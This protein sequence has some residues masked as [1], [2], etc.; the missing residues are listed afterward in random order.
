[1]QSNRGAILRG[2]VIAGGI[3]LFSVLFFSDKTHLTGKN[4]TLESEQSQKGNVSL[5]ALAPDEKTD[6]WIKIVEE[7]K[8]KVNT[9]ILDSLVNHLV[10]RRRFDYALKYAEMK[11]STDSSVKVQQQ[12]GELALNAAKMETIAK[13][14]VLSGQFSQKSITYLE[15]VLSKDS[16]NEKA[17]ISLGMAYLASGKPENSMRGILTIRKVTEINPENVEAQFQLGLRSLQTGQYEKA[18]ARFAKVVSIEPEN[19]EAKYHLGIAKSESGKKE[20]AIKL[21]QEVEKGTKDAELK[22]K[23]KLLL[24]P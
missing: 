8:G 16:L 18:E 23:V 5:P 2:G 22:Q 9:A 1:M 20:E 19:W 14:S 24:N 17:L 15:K 12:A 6:K 13:D 4:Q 21:W 7:E 10:S 11:M 3:L